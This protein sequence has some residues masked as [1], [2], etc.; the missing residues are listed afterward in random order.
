MSNQLLNIPEQ[1]S[2]HFASFRL[3]LRPHIIF[4][5]LHFC[6][7]TELPDVRLELCVVY[8]VHYLLLWLWLIA[9]FEI[10]S[11][12]QL[13]LSCLLIPDWL[14]ALAL[15]QMIIRVSVGQAHSHAALQ[16]IQSINCS[17]FSVAFSHRTLLDLFTLGV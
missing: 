8:V 13:R 10:V 14:L 4:L 6:T 17:D 9:P 11:L 1:T 2:A 7:P 12:Q 3:K 5:L 15:A 16:A